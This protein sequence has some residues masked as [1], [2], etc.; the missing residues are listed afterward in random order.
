MKKFIAALIVMVLVATAAA[1]TATAA[2]SFEYAHITASGNDP[3]AN[4]VFHDGKSIDPDTVKWAAVKYRTIT[5]KDNTGVQLIGQFYIN[6]AAEPFIPVKY[7]HTQ[8]WETIVVDM[9]T[10]SE[11]AS[12]G[13]IWNSTRYT[14]TTAI[15]F[16]PLE[17]NRDAE[18]ADGEHDTAVVSDGDCIDIAWI[19]FFAS[20][21][22]AKAYDGTQDTPAAV[23]LPE[24]LAKGTGANAI[25]SVEVMTEAGADD[26][27]VTPDEPGNTPDTSDAA[28][29]AIAA[30][31]CVA[32]AGIVVSK[33]V[34]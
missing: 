7:N 13:S 26:T 19:A 12:S 32:L 31:G 29:V 11:K 25:G 30:L 27:P 34:K 28:V 18:A 6:P 16:D 24:D 1:V 15:R 9:T 8:K 33:K 21:A 17:S 3:Y 5:E 20:E 22:D 4:F 14:G 10:V 23:L 2:G